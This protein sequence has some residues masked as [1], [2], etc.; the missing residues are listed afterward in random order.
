MWPPLFKSKS[1]F[2]ISYLNKHSLETVIHR[3][4]I[5]YCSMVAENCHHD[6]AAFTFTC[7]WVSKTI[8]LTVKI[9]VKCKHL[10]YMWKSIP[11]SN[12]NAKSKSNAPIKVKFNVK[13]GRK[14]NHLRVNQ[15]IQRLAMPHHKNSKITY[16]GKKSGN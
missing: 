4:Q 10:N 14:Q 6:F 11:K 2:R 9:Q 16:L 13:H 7:V 12:A 8:N 15:R 3:V 5:K 1:S